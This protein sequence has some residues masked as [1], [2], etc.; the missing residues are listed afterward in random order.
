MAQTATVNKRICLSILLSTLFLLLCGITGCTLSENVDSPKA[1]ASQEAFEAFLDEQ[2]RSSFEDEL[3][4]LHYTLKDPESYGI[5]KPS[6]ASSDITSDYTVQMKEGLTE[7]QKALSEI[8]VKH[9]TEDQQR[10]YKTLDKYLTQQIALCDYLQFVNLLSYGTGLSSNLP[11]T[12]AEYAFY[13]E[14]DVKDYLSILP[15]IPELLTQA[16]EWEQALTAQ[17]YGMADFE[18]EDT[19]EQ[20]D[21]FLNP[22]DGTDSSGNTD[23]SDN[24]DSSCNTDSSGSADSSNQTNLLIETFETRLDSLSEL[25]EDQ[26]KTYIQ[27]NKELVTNTVIPA[28]SSLKNDLNALK[29]D[30]KEGKGL[31]YYDGGLEYYELLLASMTLSDRSMSTMIN[32]LEN[33]LE[34]LT[35]RITDVIMQNPEV[36]NVFAE[37]AEMQTTQTPEEMLATLKEAMKED[38][39]ELSDVTYTVNPI[40]DALKDDTTAAYYLIPPYDSPEEN[41]IYYGDITDDSTNLFMTL[42]HEGYPGHLYQQ[43][44]LLQNG[45]SPIF[46]ILDMTGYKEGWA[47]YVE[48]NATDYYDFGEYDAQYHDTLTELYR[49]NLEYGYCISSLADLYVNGKGYTR[50]NI[51][52]FIS[53][54]GLDEETASSIYEFA[55]EE[56]GTY[57]QYYIGYLEILTMRQNAEKELGD[58]FDVKEFHKEYLDLGPCYY[59]ELAE[60][61]DN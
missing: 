30:A 61:M 9:L 56:P 29:A 59:G 38:Y 54:L 23:S 53:S 58:K 51:N 26:K 28:F 12:L 49:C 6:N 34:D 13:S 16:L 52:N 45:L 47:F 50:E 15:Q 41:R 21:T 11:L 55:V 8:N 48:I 44:Y 20:I 2:F 37:E 42:A 14:E 27:N 4:N 60:Y 10:I 32:S 19:I 17:G 22:S 39:P 25:S 36:Y 1:Q 46:Y 33:R 40:P 24:T 18:I 31:Y 7:A 57:L 3:I 5:E 43:N 35:E